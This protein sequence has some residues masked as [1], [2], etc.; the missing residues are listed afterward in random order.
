MRN[1]VQRVA[2]TNFQEADHCFPVQGAQFPTRTFG[3]VDHIFA[4]KILVVAP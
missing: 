1:L 4:D 3:P 2:C